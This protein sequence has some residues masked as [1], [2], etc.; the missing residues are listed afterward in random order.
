YVHYVLVAGIGLHRLVPG[1]KQ[2]LLIR[3]ERSF[4]EQGL[5][6]RQLLS[7]HRP[8]RRE[9]LPFSRDSRLL[10]DKLVIRPYRFRYLGEIALALGRNDD[11]HVRRDLGI[12]RSEEHTS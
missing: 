12:E 3:I 1:I 8:G 7:E 10:K 4:R 5:Y 6:F 9:L 2:R 11:V